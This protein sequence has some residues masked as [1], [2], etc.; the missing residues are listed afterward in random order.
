M[1]EYGK[2]GVSHSSKDA[3]LSGLVRHL[4]GTF[5]N[6]PRASVGND[7]GYF[8]SVVE[9]EGSPLALAISTDSVGTKVLVAQMAGKHDTVG[10][11]CV[12]MNANDV[13][14][15][16]ADPVTLVDYIGVNFVDAAV[17]E[18]LG[19]GLAEGA[20]RAEIS[21]PGGEIAQVRDLVNGWGDGCHY[22]LIGTCVGVVPRDR[23][24]DGSGCIPGDVVIGIASTGL[25]SNGLSLARRVL[26]E[27]LKLDI[28]AQLA[29]CCR[30]VAEE[31]LE[32][33]GMYVR[34]CKA[35][36][37]Q[38]VPVHAMINVTGGSFTNLL[39]VAAPGV[40]FFLDSLPE[41]Q[42]IFSLLQD[43]GK[44]SDAEM[45]Q[46]FNMG[47][48]FAL[49]VPASA[50]DACIAAAAA[51]GKRAQV[52]GRVVADAEK[53]LV[54]SSTRLRSGVGKL[55]VGA[56]SKGELVLADSTPRGFQA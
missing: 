21:I 41:P 14:C 9:T 43:A 2:S 10:I 45:H 40:G 8:A 46:V 44:V 56:K 6:N 35:L 28:H 5:A 25:H 51:E 23:V 54:I 33:T 37:R 49:V 52:I 12:A 42:A 1:S 39:R 36:M 48:G 29:E 27:T 55:L 50:A 7:H 11:D 53:R 38:G 18:Q 24:N 31:L 30:S 32:P 15:V 20:R 4:R 34:E 16:G 17:M 26:F 47:V 3:G 13:V 19:K 22:D